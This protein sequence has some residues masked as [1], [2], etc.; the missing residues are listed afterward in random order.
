VHG[1]QHRSLV[2]IFELGPDALLCGWCGQEGSR[3]GAVDS[4]AGDR[5]EEAGAEEDGEDAE[6]LEGV[7]Y[8]DRVVTRTERVLQARAEVMRQNHVE[9]VSRRWQ[10]V[11]G[12]RLADGAGDA[13]EKSRGSVFAT[14]WLAGSRA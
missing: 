1:A 4:A 13:E 5:G 11:G 14:A 6:V 8:G 10:V 2:T 9:G 3:V 7:C 12:Q